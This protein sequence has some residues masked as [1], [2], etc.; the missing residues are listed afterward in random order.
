MLNFLNEVKLSLP[1]CQHRS[2]QHPRRQGRILGGRKASSFCVVR[3]TAQ[4]TNSN[5]QIVDNALV[6][7]FNLIFGSL[8]DL[9]HFV[10]TVPV[11]A[12]KSSTALNT[13]PKSIR[14]SKVRMSTCCS[15]QITPTAFSLWG[16]QRIATSWYSPE[17]QVG[18]VVALCKSSRVAVSINHRGLKCHL[19]HSNYI[20]GATNSQNPEDLGWA[21]SSGRSGGGVVQK[22]PASRVAADQQRWSSS[23]GSQDDETGLP[24][25]MV[26]ESSPKVDQK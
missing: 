15:L 13:N 7:L 22:Q 8:R 4:F 21:S 16:E 11:P 5:S 26:C 2:W 3:K 25:I 24:K 12:P 18:A 19:A 10:F 14:G 20:L 1:Y 6:S 9:N 23:T 17:V